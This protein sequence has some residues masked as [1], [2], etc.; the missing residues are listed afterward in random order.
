MRDVIRL[1]GPS[2]HLPLMTDRSILPRP[3]TIRERELT[4]WLLEHGQ[5]SSKKLIGQLAN[6]FVSGECPCGCA[7]FDLRVEGTA[8]DGEPGLYVVA[9]FLW[10]DANTNE[11]GIF[12]F[13]KGGNLAGVELSDYTGSGND[14]ELPHPS[15]LRLSDYNL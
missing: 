4:A 6:A 8:D 5:R 7:S 12:V 14:R 1:K 10:N 11:M 15:L 2:P 3:L 9:D 13:T